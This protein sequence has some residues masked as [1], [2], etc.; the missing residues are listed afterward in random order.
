MS[1]SPAD[2]RPE[3]EDPFRVGTEPGEAVPYHLPDA[4]REPHRPQVGIGDPTSVVAVDRPSRSRDGGGSR[5]RRT[6]FGGL[7]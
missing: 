4:D 1:K 5:P 6:G 3:R 2:D 7:R